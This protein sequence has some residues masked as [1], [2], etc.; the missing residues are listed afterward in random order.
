MVNWIKYNKKQRASG[1]LQGRRLELFD[2]L[3][4][5]AEQYRK[6]NQNAYAHDQSPVMF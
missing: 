2:H 3:L 4:T 6:I 5:L 1:K